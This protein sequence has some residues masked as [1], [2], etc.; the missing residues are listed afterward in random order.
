MKEAYNYVY[1]FWLSSLIRFYPFADRRTKKVAEIIREA[2]SL[3][4]LLI[5]SRIKS[6]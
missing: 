4:K 3:G 5:K 1:Y 2:A 6:S